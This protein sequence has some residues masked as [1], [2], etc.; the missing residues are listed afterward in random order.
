MNSERFELQGSLEANYLNIRLDEPAQF[1]EIAMKVIKQDCPE[2][3]IPFR[4]T[5]INDT[6]M[7]K[8]KLVNATALEYAVITLHKSEFI[9]MY[10]NLLTPFVKGRDW[11]LDYHNLC[12]DT[13]YVYL[14]KHFNNAY[15]IY[16]PEASFRNSDTEILE[17]FNK[18]LTRT[19]IK[20]DDGFQVKLFRYFAGAQVTLDG[21]YRMFKE[22]EGKGSGLQQNSA[23][24]QNAVLQQ[25][26]AM[27]QNA[28]PQKNAVLQQNAVSGQ[29]G[30]SQPQYSQAQKP[31]VAQNP[32]V[33]QN[34]GASN[35]KSGVFGGFGN[36]FSGK[37]NEQAPEV[38]MQAPASEEK[39]P[40]EDS[41]N[42]SAIEAL[43]DSGKKPARKKAGSQPESNKQEEKH[44][45]FGFKKDKDAKKN[46]EGIPAMN[47]GTPMQQNVP[48]QPNVQMQPNVQVKPNMSMQQNAP[49][50]QAPV[51]MANVQRN[52]AMA[53]DET[54]IAFD[55]AGSLKTEGFL[56]LAES[57]EPGAPQRIELG[58]QTPFITVGRIS[59]DEV[60]PDI[61]FPANFKRIGRRHARIEK[62]DGNYYVIDL[63][64][65]NHTMLNRQI[66]VP[67]QPYL[68]KDGMELAFTVNHPVRYIVHL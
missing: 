20:D 15:F 50:Q 51:Q 1:D 18:V 19:E 25:N 65:A 46:G 27:Q 29:G 13:R 66:M 56:E 17:F 34:Q 68:L 58:F 49:Y 33:Q 32:A 60:K 38:K 31:N 2:F 63:G 45:I 11:F 30:M 40:W 5:S 28:V 41:D 62:K 26:T 39:A 36:I 37:K 3:L 16:V 59:S 64:S 10:L 7:L 43:F 21:L 4:V 57:E 22:E 8:Y 14:D 12:I 54:E 9:K 48:L 61:A 6:V 53:D 44:G 42:D 55:G 35:Q 47:M 23:M 24:K 52:M 67:N